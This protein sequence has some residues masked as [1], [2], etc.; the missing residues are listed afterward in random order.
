MRYRWHWSVD[1]DVWKSDTLLCSYSTITLVLFRVWVSSATFRAIMTLDVAL[2]SQFSRQDMYLGVC[3]SFTLLLPSISYWSS[4]MPSSESGK[5][6]MGIPWIASLCHFLLRQGASND[7]CM[8][9][10]AVWIRGRWAMRSLMG[11]LGEGVSIRFPEMF[12]H[13]VMMEML[14][15]ALALRRA[16]LTSA[17]IWILGLSVRL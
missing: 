6:S 1:Q 3:T 17:P 2:P 5:M 14:A 7:W 13:T 9:W 12:L 4:I 15:G 10:A 8:D 11:V 16:A